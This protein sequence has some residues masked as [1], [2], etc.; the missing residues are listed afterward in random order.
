MLNA[1]RWWTVWAHLLL[2]LLR[3]APTQHFSILSQ[4]VRHAWRSLRR[5]PVIT[6]TATLTLALGV[7]ATTAVFSVVHAVLIR[8]L[9]YLEADRLVELFESNAS[10]SMRASALNYLSWAERSNSFDAIAAFGNTGLTLTGDGD[11]DL[12]NGSLVTAS[13]FDVLR[14]SPVAGRTLRPD[15]ERRTPRREPT[16]SR[17]SLGTWSSRATKRTSGS[18]KRGTSPAS[19]DTPMLESSL[20]GV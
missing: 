10:A 12:L 17:T 19:A 14:I 1:E 7:G 5:T 8:P 18:C 3:T 4:D 2:D 16:R 11:P 13:L 15:D 20:P 6:I 9:P